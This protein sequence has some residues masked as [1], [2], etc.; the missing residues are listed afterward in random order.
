MVLGRYFI[1]VLSNLVKDFS[2]KSNLWALGQ[3]KYQLTCNKKENYLIEF[4]NILLLN[5]WNTFMV[6]DCITLY[7]GSFDPDWVNAL[8][9]VTQLMPN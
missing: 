4:Q 8:S 6:S 1:L 7:L 9:S 5:V 3:N 2:F